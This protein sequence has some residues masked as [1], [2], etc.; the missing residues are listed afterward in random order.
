[1]KGIAEAK[2]FYE[3]YGA[4]MLREQF[5]AYENRIAVGLAGRGSEC[6]G[7]D[8]AIS[9]DH[10]FPLGFCLW[11]TEA[12]EGKIGLELRRAYRA[13]PWERARAHSAPA[14]ENRGVMSI[15]DFC[16][17]HIGSAGAPKSWQQWLALP[18][19]ALAEATNGELWW[20]PL[21]AF[22]ALRREL[23]TGMPEDVRKKKLA[24]RALEMAQSGQYNYSRCLRHGEQGAAMLALADFVRSSCAAIYLLNRRHMPYYKWCLRGM[25]SLPRL[26]GQKQKLESLLLGSN[27]PAGQ[28]RKA[29]MVEEI[30][31]ALIAEL[32]RQGLS[33][34]AWDYLEP[35]AFRIQEGIAN[36]EIR[37]L[38]ILEG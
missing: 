12:D 22:T 36:R 20:D 18:S 29:Q 33:D 27:D 23:L 10:D 14:P 9:R 4:Q 24:A 26:S 37:A 19:Y 30:A 7:Y 6:L 1:M 11:L 38:H 21:G 13:L 32:Q 34:G 2:L 3:E 5:P 28:S 35:H 31:A 17:R 8:D 25:E 15:E 16:R